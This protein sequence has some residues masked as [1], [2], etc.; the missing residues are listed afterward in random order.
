MARVQ[1]I[2]F[3][4]EM[5]IPAVG[6]EP[7]RVTCPSCHASIMTKVQTESSSRTHILALLLCLFLCWP[8][9]CVPYCTDSCQNRNHYCPQC[10]AYIG[11]YQG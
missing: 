3:L 10:N 6:P 9:V 5:V 4:I 1:I 8:C 7:S 2:R 11:T